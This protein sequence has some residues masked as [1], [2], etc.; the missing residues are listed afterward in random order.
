MTRRNPQSR[1][2][3][4]VGWDGAVG[5]CDTYFDPGIFLHVRVFVLG[6]GPI[7]GN[8][9]A[10]RSQVFGAADGGSLPVLHLHERGWTR[11]GRGGRCN[12]HEKAR[13]GGSAGR[14]GEGQRGEKHKQ[15][16]LEGRRRLCTARA[17]GHAKGRDG[18]REGED[19]GETQP[20]QELKFRSCLANQRG[21]SARQT[22]LVP[23]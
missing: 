11:R 15:R 6:L 19:D 5:S 14:R 4:R 18:E 17:S 3:S 22:S 21:T 7:D 23:R 12:R 16:G 9:L 1:G 13:Q 20:G 2:A 8:P 10:G